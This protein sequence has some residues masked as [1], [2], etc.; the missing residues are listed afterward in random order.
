MLKVQIVHRDSI[1]DLCSKDYTSDEIKHYS[2][3]IYTEDIWQ[4]SI[5]DQYHIVVELEK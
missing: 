2:N 1:I 4:R 3:V 5:N